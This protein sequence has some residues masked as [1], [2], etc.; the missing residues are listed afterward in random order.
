MGHRHHDIVR[1]D[2]MLLADILRRNAERDPE[3]IALV[4]DGEEISFGTLFARSRRLANALLGVATKGDRVAILAENVPE[5]VEAYYGVPSAGMALTFLNYRLH[6]REWAWILNNAEARVLLVDAAYLDA[7]GPVLGDVPSLERVLVIGATDDAR[8]LRYDD[9]VA[10][11]SADEPAVSV[12][13]DDVAWLIYTSG[14]TGFPKGAMLTHRNLLMSI[15]QSVIELQPGRDDR[16]LLAMPLCHVAGYTVPFQ[17]L[18][19]GLIVLMRAY[20]PEQWMQL[21]QQYGITAAALAPAMINFALQHPDVDQYDLSTITTLRY[22]AAPMPLD[23]LRLAIERFGPVVQTVFGMTELAGSVTFHGKQAHMRALAGETHLLASCGRAGALNSV[24]VVDDEMVD[25]PHGVV[26]EIVVR[27]EQVL[28]GYWANEDGTKAAFSDGWFHTG[29]MAYED[30]EGFFYIVDRK[31]D[32]IVTGG[33]NVY[34]K[35]VE[36]V[37]FGHDSVLE[38]AVIGLPDAK[39][40]ERVTAVVVL[41]GGQSVTSADIIDTCKS[42]LAGYKAPKEVIF[43]DELPKNVSGKVLKRDL[44]ARYTV[45]AS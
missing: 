43:V 25:C 13:E 21:I 5:Y 1:E 16:E 18:S 28:K 29:D 15:L 6:P 44:R 41:H 10:A 22:G 45:T 12:S 42:R 4:V 14:T 33:E 3:R 19:G 27:S 2:C 9:L 23:V 32:M 30:D 8:F 40:G 20:D 36:D 37:L 7:I 35:E 34:C 38:A 24:K 26:G 11:S 31:K 17:H 39:W